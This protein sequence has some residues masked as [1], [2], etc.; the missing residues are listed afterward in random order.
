MPVYLSRKALEELRKELHQARTAGRAAAAKAIAEARAHGDLKENAEYHAAKEAQGLLEAKIAQMEYTLGEARVVD[1]SQ[2][3][4]SN[5]RIFTTVKVLNTN[6][7]REQSFKIVSA[8]EAN[9][10]KG[11]LSVD[12]P[13]GRGLLGAKVGDLVDIQIP[14]GTLTLKVLDISL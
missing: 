11:R 8:R 10:A 5:V 1:K 4:T 3:E 9:L 7:G 2:I 6:M 14:R 12:S 13:I